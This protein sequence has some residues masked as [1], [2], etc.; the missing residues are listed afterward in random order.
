MY[1]PYLRGKQEE[2]LAFRELSDSL[3]P[4]VVPI[5]KPVSLVSIERYVAMARGG[6]RLAI[7]VNSDEGRPA[8]ALADAIAAL[9]GPLRDHATSIFPAFELRAGIPLAELR[10]F[11]LRY[12]DRLTLIVHRGHAFTADEVQSGLAPGLAPVHVFLSPGTPGG[13]QHSLPARARILVRDGFEYR[14]PN[15]AYPDVSSFDD[16][17]LQYRSLGFDGFGDFS[18]VGDRYVRGGTRANH[19]ALHLTQLR[20]DSIVTNHFVST[21]A[22][23][24]GNTASKYFEALEQLVAHT[25]SPPTPEFDTAGVNSY[26]VSLREAHFPGLGCPK[27]WSIQHHTQL[28]ERILIDGGIEASF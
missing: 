15:M 10:A 1:C 18:I 25:G 23:P 5:F 19:V 14:T 3:S 8:P 7:I 24:V 22:G 21:S 26:V 9:D 13:L 12:S 11:S 16:L 2:Q 4:L 17:T 20:G 28:V 6:L 27:R